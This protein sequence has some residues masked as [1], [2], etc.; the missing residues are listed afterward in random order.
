MSL[1]LRQCHS[2]PSSWCLQLRAKVERCVDNLRMVIGF[3]H[4]D[5]DNLHKP[6]SKEVITEIRGLYLVHEWDT[7]VGLGSSFLI[8]FDTPY[9][10]PNMVAT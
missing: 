9:N 5:L 10:Q 4:H 7:N 1:L 2:M 6:Q 8:T 3:L